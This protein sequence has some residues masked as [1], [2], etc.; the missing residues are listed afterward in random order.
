MWGVI[1]FS[2]TGGQGFI[3]K[4]RETKERTPTSMLVEPPFTLNGTHFDH[5]LTPRWRHMK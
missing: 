5:D 2:D 4:L 3:A 1:Q